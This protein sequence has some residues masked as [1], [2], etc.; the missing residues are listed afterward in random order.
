MVST[1]PKNVQDL[2]NALATMLRGK[3]GESFTVKT[4]F[5]NADTGIL[6]GFV[7]CSSWTIIRRLSA[8]PFLG[9][10]VGAGVSVSVGILCHVLEANL[11]ATPNASVLTT[12]VVALLGGSVVG[13][14]IGAHVGRPDDD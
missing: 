1:A 3:M 13:L 8:G 7:L 5:A 6:V 4:F 14:I 11:V 9:L 2:Q 12:A 10:L